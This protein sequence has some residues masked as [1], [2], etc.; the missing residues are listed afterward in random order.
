MR[1]QRPQREGEA[2]A[3]RGSRVHEELD[4]DGADRAR[5]TAIARRDIARTAGAGVAGAGEQLPHL[6]AI[7]HSFGDHDVSSV[8]AQVGGPAA[9]AAAAI[10]ADAYA[11]GNRVAFAGAPDL[12]TAA[13]EAAHVVQNRAGEGVP[14]AADGALTSP[15]DAHE[16]HA[17]AVADRVVR[18]ESAAALL[19]AAPAGGAIARKPAV[20]TPDS[21]AAAMTE[22]RAQLD[23][24]ITKPARIPILVAMLSW[25]DQVWVRDNKLADIEAACTAGQTIE[26]YEALG[27]PPLQVTNVA[28]RKHA[29]RAELAAVVGR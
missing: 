9:T 18:G 25:A 17:D 13:H 10:G 23:G 6:A 28:L 5:M 3:G 7:Q 4:E 22:L 12:H 1:E 24:G 20:E 11:T 14:R 8:R 16:Q 19:D 29:S 21:P 15:G 2:E 26:I 27:E